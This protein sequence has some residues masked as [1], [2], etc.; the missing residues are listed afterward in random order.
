MNTL[1][2]SPNG[3]VWGILA[4]L[5]YQVAMSQASPTVE[6][7]ANQQTSLDTIL[8]S[9][10]QSQSS[11]FYSTERLNASSVIT[12]L[13]EI[14]QEEFFGIKAA[15]DA[16]QVQQKICLAHPASCQSNQ[17]SISNYERTIRIRSKSL[18]SLKKVC[19]PSS[20]IPSEKIIAKCHEDFKRNPSKSKTKK[21]NNLSSH[22]E[23]FTR[24]FLQDSANSVSHAKAS[25]N[26]IDNL[27]Q[28]FLNPR[29]QIMEN[30]AL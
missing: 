6:H 5:A 1:F 10:G 27:N 11:I 21:F 18:F 24:E 13:D 16:I 3:F 8:G 14:H 2:T 26:V 30:I 19:E 15:C 20:Y 4:L 9:M 17:M 23:R 7:N 22:F 29:I 28:G 25:N 12:H